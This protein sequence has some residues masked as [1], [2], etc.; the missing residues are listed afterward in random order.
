MANNAAL[1][2]TLA[3]VAIDARVYGPNN[4]QFDQTLDP[5]VLASTS[6]LG[7][8][9]AVSLPLGEA[10]LASQLSLGVAPE[11]PVVGARLYNLTGPVR[12]FGG[13]ILCFV[14]PPWKTVEWRMVQGEGTLTPFTTYTDELGRASCRLDVTVK[15]HIVVGVAYVP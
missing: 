14:G 5:T 15:A 9:F 2:Q 7:R 12:E 10:K 11:H 6:I 4:V 1:T 3:N 13:A 8:V